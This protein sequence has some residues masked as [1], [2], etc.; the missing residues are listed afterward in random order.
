METVSEKTTK[1]LSALVIINNDRFEGYKRAAEETTDADLQTI[2]TKFC[3]QSK[4]YGEELRKHIPFTN[5]APDRDETTL[6]GK[7]Y[8]AWMD[9]KAALTEKNRK[10]ILNSCE[11]GEDVAKK[12]YDEVL[13]HSE[14][15]PGD[16]LAIIRTQRSEIQQGHDTVKSLRDSL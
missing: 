3:L 7:F 14:D 9:V 6:S 12:T 5:E 16:L 11:F 13:E 15:I 10:T 4:G 8:R 2:F 1:A